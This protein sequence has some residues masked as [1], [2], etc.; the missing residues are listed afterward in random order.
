MPETSR[1]SVARQRTSGSARFGAGIAQLQLGKY[2]GIFILIAL[3]AL[4]A[5]WMPQS[6]LTEATWVTIAQGQAITAILAVA[7]LF[8]LASGGFDLSAAQIMGFSA[9]I[10]GVLI[11]REPKIDV[12]P[13]ILLTLLVGAA[14]GAFNGVLVTVLNLGSFIATLG[15]TSLLVGAAAL[16]GNGEY[17]GPFPDSFRAI[18]RGDILGV[19]VLTVYLVI[20]AFIAWYFLEHTPWGRRVYATGANPDAARLAGI[21]TNRYV[22]WS[23]VISGTGAAVAGV[24]LASNL[25]SINQSIGPQYLLPAFAAAFLGMTQLKPGRFNIWGTVLAIYLL[26]TGVQGLR[27]AGADLWVTDVFNGL[28]LLIAVAITVFMQRRRSRREVNAKLA[29]SETATVATVDDLDTD[30]K[31]VD[32]VKS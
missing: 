22:F 6:F 20:I 9:L 32:A 13:A 5:V 29:E 21:R 7:L 19:P 8:P 24:L 3:I 31:P 2:S 25:N 30:S 12:V 27:L 23:F 28:A 14:I 11:T 17:L 16:I 4:F 15:T 26:G 18:T 10:C 1:P